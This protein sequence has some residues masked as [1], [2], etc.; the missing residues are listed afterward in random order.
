METKQERG[1]RHVAQQ[2][3]FILASIAFKMVSITNR[4]SNQ[5]YLPTVAS[6][7]PFDPKVMCALC[8]ILSA[9]RFGFARLVL[10]ASY[11][12]T[13]NAKVWYEM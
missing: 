10:Q 1:L 13:Q 3:I 9:F 7:I 2:F 5:G 12:C 4:I 6:E 11:F 8:D